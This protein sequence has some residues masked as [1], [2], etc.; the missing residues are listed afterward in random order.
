M[1]SFRHKQAAEDDIA[2]FYWL[3]LHLRVNV[4]K[5][6]N[7]KKKILFKKFTFIKQPRHFVLTKSMQQNS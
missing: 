3:I 7:V 4:R 2:N 1:D 5:E 6:S